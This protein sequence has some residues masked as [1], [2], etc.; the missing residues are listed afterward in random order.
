VRL[1]TKRSRLPIALTLLAACVALLPAGEA[2]DEL[3]SAIVLSFLRYSSWPQTLAPVLNVGV[4]GS[5]SIARILRRLVDPKP[6]NNRQVRIVELKPGADPRP[7]QVIYIA[8]ENHAEL[9]QAL[10]AARAAHVLTI[11]EA[12]KFLEYG[13]AVNL[14]VID[15]HMSFEVSLE[16]LEECKVDISSRLLRLGQ[17]RKRH[18]T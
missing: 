16:A 4:L 3:K 5:P 11:G 17:V 7:Y 1:W 15:G 2:E 14:L 13:G 8:L 12:D 18:S 9:K 10:L 6:V